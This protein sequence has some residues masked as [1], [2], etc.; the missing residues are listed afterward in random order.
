MLVDEMLQIACNYI[1]ECWEMVNHGVDRK[2]NAQDGMVARRLPSNGPTLVEL[3]TTMCL[4]HPVPH[5]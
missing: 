2:G 4:T 3:T 1:V 5:T